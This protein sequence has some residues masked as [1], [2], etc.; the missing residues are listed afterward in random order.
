MARI[1]T[2]AEVAARLRI[3]PSRVRRLAE[4]YDL[5]QKVNE[6]MR[7]YTEEDIAIMQRYST[8]VAGRPARL[9]ESL[10][11]AADGWDDLAEASIADQDPKAAAS[12]QAVAKHVRRL[13]QTHRHNGNDPI[14]QS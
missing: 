7:V 12:A 13:A 9:S 4:R 8:G 1:I 3:D 5:G 10:D 6:R 2:P 14:Q 11:Q